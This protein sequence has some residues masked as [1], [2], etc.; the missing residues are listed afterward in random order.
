MRTLSLNDY[1][2]FEQLVSLK[3]STLM[4]TM[5]TYLRRNYDNVISTSKYICAKGDIPIALVAHLDTVFKSPVENLY[6]DTR[7]NVMWSPEGLGADDRAGVFAIVKIIKM[8]Y[9][10]HIIFTTDEEIGGVGAEQITK[11]MEFPFEDMKYIIQLDRRGTNDCVFYDCDNPAFT[12]YVE[13]FGFTEAWGSFSDISFICPHWMVAGVNLSI[14]YKDE[15][16]FGE[17]LHVSPMLATIDKVVQMLKDADK[18]EHFYYVPA[19]Y[20]YSAAYGWNSAWTYPTEADTG[21]YTCHHCGHYFNEYELIPVK[22]K[23]GKTV[24][25]CPDCIVSNVHWCQRCNEPFEID[26]S[27][28]RLCNDCKEKVEEKEECTTLKKSKNNSKK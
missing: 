26:D 27:K 24:F 19:K 22:S 17:T 18:C 6:Y 23:E 11:D 20:S 10:P 16:S 13:S 21:Y 25:Y 15:H 8:G 1:K 14:G 7:K 5:D 9:R 28:S 12:E 2:L 3:Q 4:K